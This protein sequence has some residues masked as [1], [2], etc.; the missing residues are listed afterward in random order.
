MQNSVI[1]QVTADPVE[2]SLLLQ[3]TEFYYYFKNFNL[4]FGHTVTCEILVPN[5]I[6]PFPLDLGSWSLNHWIAREVP[7]PAQYFYLEFLYLKKVK[8]KEKGF[9]FS[10]V[11][12]YSNISLLNL[13]L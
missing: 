9:F 2:P 10:S 1:F 12:L 3:I 11:D 8:A 13:C 6:E 5:G 4:F 7:P